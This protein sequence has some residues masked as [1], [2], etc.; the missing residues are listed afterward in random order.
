MS[1]NESDDL[2]TPAEE[3]ADTPPVAW[4]VIQKRK[5][6]Y[7][8]KEG[9]YYEYPLGIP[10]SRNIEAGHLLI[11]I[12]TKDE[13][14]A[15]GGRIFG[16]GRVGEVMKQR[17]GDDQ[18][19]TLYRAEYDH[20]LSIDPMISFDGVGG[21]PRNNATNAIV[22]LTLQSIERILK[23]AGS[24]TP[25]D[26][27]E[28][29]QASESSGESLTPE[30]IREEIRNAVAND[31]LGPAMGPIEEFDGTRPSA[32]YLVGKLAPRR[33]ADPR[34]HAEEASAAADDAGGDAATTEEGSDDSTPPAVEN[35]TPSSMGITF[36]VDEDVSV[37]EVT[38]SWGR[39]ERVSSEIGA[40]DGDE[41]GD[42]ES[43]DFNLDD[44][45]SEPDESDG[46]DGGAPESRRV[47]RREPLQGTLTIDLTKNADEKLVPV[48]DVE[49]V[50]LRLKVRPSRSGNRIVSVFL[51]NEQEEPRDLKEQAWVFKP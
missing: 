41:E 14:D 30:E 37:L 43:V 9:H 17:E 47:W 10:N 27:P 5:S 48:T 2:Q 12:R 4:M 44:F 25:G 49:D 51:V 21:D 42:E 6:E 35:L 28:V 19:R 1:A 22:S 24:S 26:W 34:D 45:E 33:S 29:V 31:L 3:T 32:R 11:L 13:Q 18:D 8:D 50:K 46:D 36:A 20:Y 7:A 15:D 16:I 40:E 38:A 39:Y 23:A